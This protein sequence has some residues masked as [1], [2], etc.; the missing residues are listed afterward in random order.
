MDMSDIISGVIV[1]GRYDLVTP[2]QTA[3]D[4]H[5][6]WPNSTLYWIPDA[7]HSVFVRLASMVKMSYKTTAD[8]LMRRNLAPFP[9]CWKFATSFLGL[10]NKCMALHAT[11]R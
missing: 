7:G 10:L 3:W 5:K 8:V 2:P 9:S 6:A 11:R 1:Q 4:L